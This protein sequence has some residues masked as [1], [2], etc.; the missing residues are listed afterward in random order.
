MRPSLVPER[1]APRPWLPMAVLAVV[2]IALFAVVRAVPTDTPTPEATAPASPVSDKVVLITSDPADMPRTRVHL[3]WHAEPGWTYDVHVADDSLRAVHA[4]QAVEGGE[5]VIPDEATRGLP[6]GS[7]LM[8]RV[9]GTS[10]TGESKTSP[11]AV[12][13]LL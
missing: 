10:P 13:H 9:Q 2:A 1:E 5:L 3:Q 4:Q 12:I 7:T 11:T 6:V 8:W